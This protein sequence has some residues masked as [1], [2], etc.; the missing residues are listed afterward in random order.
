ML[1]T[2]QP[3]TEAYKVPS[4][5]I[6]KGQYILGLDNGVVVLRNMQLGDSAEINRNQI[7]S[8]MVLTFDPNWS[9]IVNKLYTFYLNCPEN[10]DRL[11]YVLGKDHAF[12]TRLWCSDWIE[13]GLIDA[14]NTRI[15]HKT[16]GIQLTLGFITLYEVGLRSPIQ[17]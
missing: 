9:R 5:T 4:T 7:I 11:Q 14:N 8:N 12:I 6:P 16:N 2:G 17:C 15:V 3:F 1:L 13:Y 10:V